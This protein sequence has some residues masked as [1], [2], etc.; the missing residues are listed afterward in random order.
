MISTRGDVDHDDAATQVDDDLA[1]QP[2]VARGRDWDREL[3]LSTDPAVT[4]V[5]RQSPKKASITTV[6]DTMAKRK[7]STKCLY[8][9]TVEHQLHLF[10]FGAYMNGHGC[11]WDSY[12]LRIF[13][14]KV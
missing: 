14:R 1:M 11:Q 13:S 10:V 4:Q 3:P 5:R 8:M 2:P 9:K 12:H 6:R 7:V